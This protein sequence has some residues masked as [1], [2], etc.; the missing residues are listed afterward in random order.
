MP[1]LL[2]GTQWDIVVGGGYTG[3]V[4][5]G[6]SGDGGLF[7]SRGSRRAAAPYFQGG[8]GL[9]ELTVGDASP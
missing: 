9:E 3:G 8:G 4:F 7:W 5:R 6:G 1:R 2:G